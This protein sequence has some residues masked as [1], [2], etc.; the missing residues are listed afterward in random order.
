[1]PSLSRPLGRRR[2]LALYYF[3]TDP[4]K[5]DAVLRKTVSG[6]TSVNA[7]LFHFAVENLPFGGIGA[8]GIGAYHGE[9]GFRP[10]RTAKASSC[11]AGLAVQDF[12]IRRS[13]A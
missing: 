5:R 11:R 7:T 2:P 8:S 12:Y 3:G 10:S 6:G 13:A 1:M 9:F 4:D